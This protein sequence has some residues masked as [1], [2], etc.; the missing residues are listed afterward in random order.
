MHSYFRN[1][2]I[3]NSDV[4]NFINISENHA[5]VGS[6]R[7]TWPLKPNTIKMRTLQSFFTHQGFQTLK[8]KSLNVAKIGFII[9]V[10]KM[11]I[12]MEVEKIAINEEFMLENL[13]EFLA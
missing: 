7:L 11:Q 13:G 6:S 10:A 8:V 5:N 12:K 9:F 3:H 1:I 2:R 4:T